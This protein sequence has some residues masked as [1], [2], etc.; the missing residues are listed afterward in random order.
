MNSDINL[1][2]GQLALSK[3]AK[4]LRNLRLIATFSLLGVVFLSVLLFLLSRV[5]S[6]ASIVE[7]QEAVM[8]N[9]ASL[10]VKQSKLSLL[11]QR[12]ND[13]SIIINK[14]A[15]YDIVLTSILA[16]SPVGVSV[17]SLSIDKQKI[18]IIVS[19]SSLL[20]MNEFIAVLKGMVEKKQY[21]KNVTINGLTLSGKSTG[22]LLTLDLDLL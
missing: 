11:G 13:I 3:D 2:S 9:I 10:Q 19:S 5:F 8:N 6:P 22:Y 17:T 4:R 12:L 21:L 14:R 1:V 16:Q 7:Q 18:S 15:N 20:S